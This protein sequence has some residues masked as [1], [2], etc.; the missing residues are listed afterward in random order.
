M[1]VG[2]PMRVLSAQPGNLSASCQT[3]QGTVRSIDL[4][5]VGPQPAGA[6]LLTHQGAAREVIDAASASAIA[7]ALEAVELAMRGGPID[8]ST[9]D[10]LFPDLAGREPELPLHLRPPTGPDN[11]TDGETR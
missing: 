7:D 3:R 5:L 4:A 2:V 6:W 9:I 8:P 11:G 10:D 1:C